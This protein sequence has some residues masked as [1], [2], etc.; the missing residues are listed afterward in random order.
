MLSRLTGNRL[1][2][3]YSFLHGPHSSVNNGMFLSLF[4]Y[5]WNDPKFICV[6]VVCSSHYL[7]NNGMCPTLFSYQW[8]V[9]QR[10]F[11]SSLRDDL[12]KPVSMS[13][14]PYVRSSVHNFLS[15]I[16][17]KLG[18]KVGGNMLYMVYEFDLDSRLRSRSLA[19]RTLKFGELCGLSRPRIWIMDG[20]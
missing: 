16:W 17:T 18:W 19:F 10:I 4:V 1:S 11:R 6:T 5:Q 8:Y 15:P 2:G 9:S 20:N 3:K 7:Y 13:V 14:R 12:I